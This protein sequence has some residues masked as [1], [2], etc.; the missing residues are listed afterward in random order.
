MLPSLQSARH[1]HQPLDWKKAVLSRASKG[2]TDVYSIQVTGGPT[3]TITVERA[4]P[5]RILKWESSDGERAELLR[6]ARLKYWQL[7]HPGN[8]S[9]LK[10]LGLSPRPP[11]TT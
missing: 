2:E 11:K 4:E 10:Q 9:Y 8:E 5:R 1:N 6:S 7:N 3:R